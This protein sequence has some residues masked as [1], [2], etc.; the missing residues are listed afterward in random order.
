MT[1]SKRTNIFTVTFDGF[2]GLS[3]QANADLSRLVL[4]ATRPVYHVTGANEGKITFAN[5]LANVALTKVRDQV[6]R[7]TRDKQSS[8]L[9]SMHDVTV[10]GMR[11]SALIFVTCFITTVELTPL[12]YLTPDTQRIELTYTYADIDISLLSTSAPP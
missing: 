1:E 6:R 9:L 3:E 8:F 2:A 11:I 12:D 4:S 5:D 7:Q 10:Q